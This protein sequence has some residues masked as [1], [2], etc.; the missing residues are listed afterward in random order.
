MALFASTA[1]PIE[2]LYFLGIGG[3]A[4]GSVA[5]ACQKLGYIVSGCDS[6]VYPPMSQMLQSATIDYANGY[7]S[8]HI[9]D[10]A[11]DAVIVG[12]AISRGNPALEAA[13]DHNMLLL[14]MP[15][16]LRWGFMQYAHRIV[17]A[18]THGK[19]T[20]TSLIAWLLQSGGLAT[21]YLIGGSVPA[22]GDSCRP[23][24]SGGYFVLEGDEYDT[25]FFD[26]RSKFL[27]SMPHMLVVT[28]IEFD[29]ADMFRS[30][31]DVF[32]AFSKLVRLVPRNGVVLAC[33]DD[34]GARMLSGQSL[35]PV[36]L[37]GLSDRCSWRATTV[38][39]S[40]NGTKFL[41]SYN[42]HVVGQFWMR[43]HGDHNIRN[44]T[45][46]IAIAS[47]LGLSAD[48]IAAALAEFAPPKRRFEILCTWNGATVIDDFA[49]HP[50]AISATL[51]AAR[52]RFPNQRIIACFEPRSNTSV[53][54]VFQQELT[55]A[56]SRADVV[57]VCPL[58][59]GERYSPQERLDRQ[60]LETDLRERGIACYTIPESSD[61][62]HVAFNML[63][64]IAGDGDVLLLLS[65]GNI[66]G[67]RDLIQ[68]A[69]VSQHK[70]EQS[71]AQ[72]KHPERE[73]AVD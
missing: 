58:Y 30:F 38:E 3:I 6:G 20:T 61:W 12:N 39:R 14:S 33:G 68:H 35:S 56:L 42:G 55:D 48:R 25:A 66:G 41:V 37:Y 4:M 32:D 50:T 11:P 60:R 23:A 2:R 65:N 27:H 44:A 15:E 40:P 53:R 67:L 18:G 72:A 43:L 70:P 52:E 9:I 34:E 28:S 45:A 13:L 5:I 57:V 22:L 73:T 71:P 29:H 47:E 1:Q 46:A 8:Q 49:H 26:K 7:S 19:T 36:A 62:G 59:R 51:Q 63:A 21:G 54:A 64:S 16:L 69:V 10:F 17:V 24:P 31:E